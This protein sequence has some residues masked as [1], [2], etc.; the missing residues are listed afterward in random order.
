MIACADRWEAYVKLIPLYTTHGDWAGAYSQGNL[1]NQMGEW[2]GWVVPGTTQVFSVMGEYVGWLS[3]DFRVLR[4]R[5]TTNLVP[6][7]EPPPQPSRLKMPASVPL[8]PLMAD[9]RFDIVD[10]VEEMP[11]RL[12]TLDFIEETRP[13]MD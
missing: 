7:R 8:A 5:S 10:V 9:L 4:K 3:K 1:Y 11:E 12:H 13:D 6:K 2:V